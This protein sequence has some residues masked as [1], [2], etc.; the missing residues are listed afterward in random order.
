MFQE[1]DM[2]GFGTAQLFLNFLLFIA[3]GLVV[4]WIATLVGKNRVPALTL[5]VLFLVLMVFN[6]YVLEWDL[7]HEGRTWF[8]DQGGITLRVEVTV[9]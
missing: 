6:H 8:G 9:E 7:V 5:S 1:N 4:G 3:T 2:S